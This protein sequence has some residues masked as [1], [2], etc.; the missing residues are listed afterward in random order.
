LLPGRTKESPNWA[1]AYLT[2]Q[3]WKLA[4]VKPSLPDQ[5][6]ELRVPAELHIHPERLSRASLAM[7]R[8]YPGRPRDWVHHSVDA[9][10]VR[11]GKMNHILDAAARREPETVCDWLEALVEDGTAEASAAAIRVLARLLDHELAAVDTV[12][13]ALAS[14]ARKAKIVLTEGNGFVA[15]VAG[16]VFRRSGEDGLRDDLVYVDQEIS[17]DPAILRHL[18]RLGIRDADSRGRFHSVL[19]QGFRGYTP[20]SWTRFWELMR[21]A[22]GTSQ[23]GAIREKVQDVPATLQVRTVAG[24]FRAIKDCLLPGPV[25]PHDGSRDAALAVDI[26]FHTDDL[27]VLREL[28]MTDRPTKGHKPERDSWFRLYHQAAHDAYCEELDATA[29]RVQLQTVKLEGSP[30]AGPLHL[31]D[32]LSDQSKASFLAAIPEDG[33]IESWT[34]QIGSSVSTRVAVPSPIRWLLRSYGTVQTSRGLVAVR[35]AVGPQLSAYAAVLPVAEISHDKARRL[36]LPTSADAVEPERWSDLLEMAK[37]STDDAFVGSAY[38]LLIRVALD[39]VSAET[40]VRCR[41]GDRWEQRPD[42]DIAVAVTQDQ[43]EEL[44]RENHPALLVS[45]GDDLEQAEYMIREWGM[46]RVAEVIEKRLRSVSSGAAV[47]LTDE[48]PPLRQRLGTRANGLLLQRCTELE[49]V[50]RTPQ[51]TRTTALRSARQESTALV[52]ENASPE[53][54]LVLADREF[55]WG[56]GADGCRMLIEAHRR[57]QEDHAFQTRL[58]S[59]RRSGSVIEKISMLI[60]ADDL[61]KGLPA[62]LVDS[63]VSETGQEPDAR[64]LAEMAFN[65]H[66]DGVLRVHTKDIA[67]QFPNAPSRFDGGPTALRFVTDLG[68]P[69]TFAGVRIPA[70]PMRVEAEGPTEFPA[71]HDYQERIATRLADLLRQDT[72]QR[73]MLSLPTGAGKTRVASEGVIRWIRESGAPVG[74]ILWIAQTN[75]LCE[76][77]VQSWKFVWEKVGPGQSLVI[78]RLW[79]TNSATPVTGRPHLIVATDAKL[80]ICLDSAQYDWLQKASL[81]LVDEAHVAVSSTYTDILGKLGLTHRETRRHLVGLTAT[82]F[83][84]DADLTHRLVQRFGDRRLDEGIFPGDPIPSLQDLGVLSQVEHR[85]LVGADMQLNTDELATLTEFNGFLPKAAEQR[86][87]EDEDRN[88]VLVEEIAALPPDWPVLVFATSVQHAKFLAAKLSDRDIR[89]AAIDSATPLQERRLRVD[90]FRTGKI[91]VI[92]NYGVLSQGFDAP[93]TRAVVI[94]RPVYSAN[95]YQQM[96]GRGLR[97]LRNGGKESCLILDMRDNVTNFHKELAFTDFEHLWRKEAP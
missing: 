14:E 15:P 30:T 8:E 4:A 37:E 25:V 65:A 18:D 46:R 53:E 33:L 79:H 76:Q 27:P 57:Q 21:S 70:L 23:T 28:G 24:T 89:S 22:G 41:V 73:A 91:R 45:S 11:R 48:Y 42:S 59:I 44:I 3:I 88:N 66:D 75:E 1:C 9:H 64:R 61:R 50:V 72:P 67:A 39:L 80:R 16:R 85:E 78:D 34:R 36:G 40:N 63:E 7:W 38:A 13:E 62:G 51:G 81:V 86:L 20:D 55:R 69:D 19:D 92:T 31:F 12:H 74:P 87:A 84:N 10:P 47:L 52:P 2:D 35:D 82:P 43:Y 49:E 93:A 96:V 77:A 6:G 26:R 68:F 97:G 83:R 54:A 71:L 56:L 29:K 58:R 94:A 95:I 60:T 90:A 17:G 32:Q 5:D